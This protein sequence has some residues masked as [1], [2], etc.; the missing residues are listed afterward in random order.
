MIDKARQI[1]VFRSVDDDVMIDAEQVTAADA[2]GFVPSLEYVGDTPPDDLTDILDDHLPLGDRFHRK[3][4]PV[5]NSTPGKF[6][7]FFANLK[8]IRDNESSLELKLHT[9][10]YTY[11]LVHI[12]CT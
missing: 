11:K 10:L 9:N 1:S 2:D 8:Q 6:Q 5:V 3:Q 7:L 12:K 4:T